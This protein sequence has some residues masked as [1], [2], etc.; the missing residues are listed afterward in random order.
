MAFV[1]DFSYKLDQ[2]FSFLFIVNSRNSVHKSFMEGSLKEI[3]IIE[4]EL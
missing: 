2:L 1:L 4:T 3:K